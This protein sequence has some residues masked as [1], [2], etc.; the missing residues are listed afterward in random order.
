MLQMGGPVEHR[1]LI[2]LSDGKPNDFE[3]DE[4][5]YGFE[6]MRHAVTEAKL[7]AVSPFRSQLTAKPLVTLSSSSNVAFIHCCLAQKVADRAA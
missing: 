6:D 5:C 2:L 3:D 1:L 7:Q 4:G